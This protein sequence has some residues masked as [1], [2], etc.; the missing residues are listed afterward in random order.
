MIG[1][2]LFLLAAP[3]LF[4]SMIRMIL[5]SVSAGAGKP[6]AFENIE[7]WLVII[8]SRDE[9]VHLETTLRSLP[10]DGGQRVKCILLLDGPD[11]EGEKVAARFPVI[12]RRKTPAGPTKAAALRWL[13]DS[14]RETVLAADA[15]LLLDVG[16]SLSPGF[17]ER[18]V[19]PVGADG[20]QAFLRGQGQGPGEAAAQSEAFAQNVEDR[21]R[22]RLGWNVRLRGTGTALRPQDFVKSVDALRTQVEDLEASLLLSADGATLKMA[23][24]EAWVTDEKPADRGRAAAQRA[25]WLAGKLEILVRHIPALY[26]LIARSPLEG[27]AFVAEMFGRPLSLSVLLRIAAGIVLSFEGALG[28]SPVGWVLAAMLLASAAGDVMLHSRQGLRAGTAA[29]LGVSWLGAVVLSPRALVRWMRAR[30]S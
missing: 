23:G 17:F 12:I 18:L 26:R 3:S 16:S 29:N 30:K 2:L 28:D 24:G 8:P 5:V 7:R 9:G 27:A 21:G 14:D 22:E 13:L 11:A 6:E 10:A 19:W 4:D 1:S 25:R 20:V 15:V